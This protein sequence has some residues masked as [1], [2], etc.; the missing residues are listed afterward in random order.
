M[1]SSDRKLGMDR[2]ISRRD[3]LQGM[4]TLSAAAMLPTPVLAGIADSAAPSR[5]P[6]ALTGLRGSHVG[7]FEVAHQ[8]ARDGRVD[9]GPV[10]RSDEVYDLVVV[11]AGISGLS[12]AHFYRKENPRASILILDNHDDFGGHA[13]RNEFTVNDRTLIGHGGSQTLQE[14]SSYSAVVKGLL[15]DL[16]VDVKQFDRGAYDQD[17]FTRNG[18]RAGIYFNRDQW[19]VD[20]TVPLEIGYFDGYIPL[21]ASSLSAQQAVAQMPISEK[22]KKQFLRLLTLRQDQIPEI[23]PDDKWRYLS[24]ISYRD[25][26]IKHIGITELEVFEVLQDLAVDSGLGIEAVPAI[27]AIGYMG[28]PGWDAAGLPDQEDDE[29]YIHH[30]PD[31]NASIARLIVRELIPGVASGHSMEDVVT[32]DFDYS[33]LDL[34]DSIARIRLDSTVTRVENDGNPK[35]SKGVGVTYVRHGQTFQVRAAG[36]VLACNSRIIPYLCPELPEPQRKALSRQVKM[37][38]LYTSVALRNWQ[39]WKKLGIGGVLAPGSY[40]INATL[41]FPVSLGD[42]QYSSGPDQPVIVHMERFPHRSNSGLSPHEQ[43][44]L[45]RHELYTTSFETIERNVRL[46]LAG[47]LGEGGF[48][49]AEDILGITVNRWAHGYATWYNPLFETVYE[50]DDDERYPHMQARK[51]FGRI[52]IAN[53]DSAA[54][55]MLEAAVEQGYRAVSELS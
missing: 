1:K 38:I 10:E 37:P 19:G 14:P 20:R 43:Y 29:A 28:L 44:R 51:P 4:G 13:K 21:A 7:S 24:S 8:L 40:H 49:P 16:G 15:D 18:L 25:F 35:S 22:A 41:D 50:D 26:L 31:G 32:A 33:K 6:P 46:Q 52:T 45:G 55:A 48:D 3:L 36:C 30:F 54:N 17:F 53:A 42:Y 5:Y 47:M 2:P 9:W 11:G 27:G 39:A 34:P 12:A 23:S